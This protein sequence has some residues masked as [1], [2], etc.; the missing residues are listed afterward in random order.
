MYKGICNHKDDDCSINE[1]C[2]FWEHT[3]F[4]KI[5][6]YRLPLRGSFHIKLMKHLCLLHFGSKVL[7]FSSGKMFYY[8]P[9]QIFS[10]F[11]FC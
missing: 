3:L 11:F 5:A 1:F 8:E 10:F 9:V 6:Y 2:V 4:M 7:P